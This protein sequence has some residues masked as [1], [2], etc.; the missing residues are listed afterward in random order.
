MGD[1]LDQ[2]SGVDSLPPTTEL[3]TV[4]ISAAE[5]SALV[6]FIKKVVPPILEEESF[7]QPSLVKLLEEVH[8]Q[9]KLRKFITDPL[10]KSLLIQRISTK[11]K[12]Q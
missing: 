11:G 7:L 8:V 5:V 4:K 12:C 6:N 1:S 9:E 10:I 3:A 2:I